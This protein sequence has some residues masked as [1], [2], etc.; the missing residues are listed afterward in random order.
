MIQVLKCI[1]NTSVNTFS[2]AI[3]SIRPLFEEIG[4]GKAIRRTNVLSWHERVK[5]RQFVSARH[6]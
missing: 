3:M 4:T 1:A 5:A 6:Y 2:L